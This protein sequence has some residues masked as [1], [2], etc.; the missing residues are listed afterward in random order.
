MGQRRNGAKRN[1][2]C[3]VV[4]SP[5]PK[6]KNLRSYE[7]CT[8]IDEFSVLVFQRHSLSVEEKC[9]VGLWPRRIDRS[10]RLKSPETETGARNPAYVSV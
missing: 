2:I 9:E 7:T 3:G 5:P 10:S 1:A 4:I 8:D 6:K